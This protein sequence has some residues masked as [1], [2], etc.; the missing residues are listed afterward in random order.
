MTYRSRKWVANGIGAV[1]AAAI[2]ALA[3]AR[4]D[5][6]T[7]LCAIAAFGVLALLSLV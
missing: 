3:C 5:L 7:A 6:V 4:G 2:F 1:L